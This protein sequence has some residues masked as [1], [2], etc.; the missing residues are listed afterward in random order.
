MY[1]GFGDDAVDAIVRQ[2][3]ILKMDWPAVHGELVDLACRF[4]EFSECLDTAV[5]EVV[6]DALKFESNF[7]V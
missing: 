6:Y 7:Y 3:R 5:R 2:A 1:T 4:P